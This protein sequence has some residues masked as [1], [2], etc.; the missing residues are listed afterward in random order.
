MER[1][2]SEL[3]RFLGL[4]FMFSLPHIFQTVS[5]R[6]Q[7]TQKHQCTLL[8]KKKP[9]VKPVPIIQKEQASQQDRKLLEN[10]LSSLAK[11]HRT[12]LCPPPSPPFT[13]KG[14]VGYLDLHPCWA[15]VR[16][17]SSSP[18]VASEEAQMG[19][20]AFIVATEDESEFPDNVH[21]SRY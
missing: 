21:Q 8:S 2:S 18:R 11:Y 12:K 20:E 13:V 9:K 17:H 6:S 7:Q 19:A 3:S 5:W 1:H 4:G 10:N 16:Y 15:I 14:Q